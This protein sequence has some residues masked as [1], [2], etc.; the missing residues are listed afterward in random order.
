MIKKINRPVNT[1][2]LTKTELKLNFTSVIHVCAPHELI[3]VFNLIM[4]NSDK[5]CC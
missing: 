1:K 3:I 5:I 4:N 2:F